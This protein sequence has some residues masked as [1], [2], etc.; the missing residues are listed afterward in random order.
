MFLRYLLR[1]PRILLIS[2]LA[3][4]LLP[5][6]ALFWLGWR[7]FDQDRALATER[8][9]QQRERAADLIAVALQQV[10]GATQQRL[11]RPLP[12]T[13]DAVL[14]SFAGER[15]ESTPKLLFYPVVP[16]PAQPPPPL[17]VRG[18]ELEFKDQNY[19]GAVAALRGLTASP[20]AAVRAG[21]HLRI[22]RNLRK[23]GKLALALD[24]YHE[25]AQCGPAPV[26]GTPAD[27]VARRARFALLNQLERKSE[28]R[29]EAEAI[30]SDL[31][32]GRWQ[33]TRA[34]FMH[35]AE[36]TGYHPPPEAQAFAEAVEWL[37]D[38][39]KLTPTGQE[40]VRFEALELTLL[41][42]DNRALVAGPRY[43]EQHWLAPLGP[44]LKSQAVR[45]ALDK[46]AL[47]NAIVR[48]RGA[49]GLPWPIT[50]MS[51]EPDA[52]AREFRSRRNFLLAV[53]GLLAAVVSAAGYT[54]IRAVNR[55]FAAAR[56]QSDFVAAVSHEFRTPLT[57]LRQISEIFMEH[58]ATEA[59]REAY[60]RAQVRATERLY[61][62]VE[63]L[64]DFRRM[65]AGAK[66]YRLQPLDPALLVRKVVTEFQGEAAGYS[67]ELS[68]EG[69]LPA[70]D[71]DSDALTHAVW[72]LLDNAV[73]YSPEQRTIWVDL[74]R[75]GSGV[76]IAVR[77]KGLGIP[78]VEQ[79]AIFKKF[80]RGAAARLHEIKG[81]GIGLA[82][83]RNI[84]LAHGGKVLLES[85]PGVGSTFTILLP[86]GKQLCSES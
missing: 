65:E 23:A 82:M 24:E 22:A 25:M 48:D 3:V 39:R 5:A 36:A 21:A 29:Q 43:T 86:V 70:V 28:A 74:G 31:N 52:E 80:V 34:A 8:L 32:A 17:F 9:R 78:A 61:R 73:K 63:S 41:W 4:T 85:A 64:L 2:F 77:D 69:D 27:L 46:S 51:A 45:L 11:D 58:R 49:T 1:P 10:L 40:R 67:L 76:A 30:G 53:F 16:S 13:Q 44:L 19:D 54:M 20:D 79:K 33:L 71:A 68:I 12:D 75:Q 15:I 7:F 83:V 84:V 14:V 26:E 18:E 47:P 72:N 38:R 62:L 57:L 35:H 55:E 56:L 6:G 81:T 37:W 59:Q 60:Y 66:P 42:R 50:V